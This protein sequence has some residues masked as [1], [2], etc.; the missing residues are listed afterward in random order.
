MR[1]SEPCE[2]DGELVLRHAC[3]LSLEGVVSKDRDAPY[4]SGRG[5][6]WV[7]SKCTER[8]ELVVAGFVPSTTS[9]KA[10]GSLLLGYYEGGKFVYAGR[11][12][13]GFTQKV[14]QDLYKRLEKIAQP[15]SPFARKLSAEEAR[16]A[17][18]ARPE[19][20]AEIEFR[21]WTADGVIR[22][23]SFRGLRADQRAEEVVF[24]KTSGKAGEG[25]RASWR[26]REWKSGESR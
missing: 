13:T 17:K 24:E 8:Q 26:E 3:R 21:A 22:H 18:F 10:I 15:K 19:L 1:Y 23:A 6:D 25:G 7:K 14:A 20:V 2:E 11:V 12:G 5:K 9:R 4:R 16:G